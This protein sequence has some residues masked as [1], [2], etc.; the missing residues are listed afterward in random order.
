MNATQS[1]IL[2]NA[3]V[4]AVIKALV[5]LASVLNLKWVSVMRVSLVLLV[6][7]KKMS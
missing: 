2:D 1:G 7:Y 5:C 3:A 4:H 6:F